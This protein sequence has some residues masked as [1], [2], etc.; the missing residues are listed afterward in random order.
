MLKQDPSTAGLNP[1]LQERAD[2]AAVIPICRIFRPM[3]HGR[4]NSRKDS[5][6]IRTEGVLSVQTIPR[7]NSGS[8]HI[9][10]RNP[11]LSRLSAME[12][13]FIQRQQHWYSMSNPSL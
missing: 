1:Q 8:L 11:G 10:A 13:I 2:S 9:S 5:Y 7:S 3:E 6:R 12:G 4:A